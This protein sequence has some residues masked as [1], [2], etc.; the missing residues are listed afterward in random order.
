MLKRRLMKMQALNALLS[1]IIRLFNAMLSHVG[2]IRLSCGRFG[3]FVAWSS[4]DQLGRKKGPFLRLEV[5]LTE[6]EA[7]MIYD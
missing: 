7:L 1:A 5:Q 6:R 3:Q 4:S 2:A